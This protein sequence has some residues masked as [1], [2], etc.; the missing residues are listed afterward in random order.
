AP[1][2]EQINPAWQDLAVG[3]EI[4]LADELALT[5]A[6][7]DPPRALVLEGVAPGDPADADD[8]PPV[9]MTWAFVLEPE[10]DAAE[11]RLVV[12][13]R[14]GH[15]TPWAGR[16]VA[17]ITWVSALMTHRM[18]RGIKERAERR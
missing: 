7:V 4:H 3:D 6:V 8:T 1:A 5:A 16:L 12:R 17:P 11:C 18:L 15:R 9:D 13:E 14:Y 10:F 2:A